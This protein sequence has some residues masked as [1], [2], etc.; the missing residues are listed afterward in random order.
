MWFL[1][2]ELLGLGLLALSGGTLADDQVGDDA[3]DQ[4]VGHGGDGDGA[5]P[6]GEG[7]WRR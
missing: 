5:H 2:D 7:A 6:G 1:L 4:G 3:Q